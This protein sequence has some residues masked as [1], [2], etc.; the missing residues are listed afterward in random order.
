MIPVAPSFVNADRERVR[1]R[2]RD[3]NVGRGGGRERLR[4][5]QSGMLRCPGKADVAE[6]LRPSSNSRSL[7]TSLP[8]SISSLSLTRSSTRCRGANLAEQLERAATSIAL[9]TAEGCS[10]FA[11]KEKGRFF[12]MALRSAGECAA[13][14]AVGRRLGAIT[15]GREDAGR[16]LLG[17]IVAM[18]T[19]MARRTGP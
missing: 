15:Q 5:F 17:R 2:Q 11:P 10:E 9:N 12:R 19:A 7:T 1:E 4:D 8:R 14:L 16:S 13:I 3:V 18:L 6:S